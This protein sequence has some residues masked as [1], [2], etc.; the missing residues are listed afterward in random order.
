MTQDLPLPSGVQSRYVETDLDLNVHYLEA[1]DVSDPVLL[2][3][4]GF[5]ELS[6]SW[7]KV[8]VPLAAAGYRVI[9]PDQRG[10]GRTTGWINGYDIDLEPYRM[11]SLVLD[12]VALLQAL[13]IDSVHAVIGHDF[14]SPV[15]AWSGLIRPDIFQKVVLMS[16]T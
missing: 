5:P 8:M 15:A 12:Q 14:G 1:G 4:H 3:L 11:S 16:A 2:L 7:R 9:A 10:Y 13:E 6:F